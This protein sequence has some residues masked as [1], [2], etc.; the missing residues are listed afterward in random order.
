MAKNPICKHCNIEMVVKN[1]GKNPTTERALI[2][3]QCPKCKAI[4]NVDTKPELDTEEPEID[5]VLIQLIARVFK[6]CNAISPPQAG[7][8][9][10]C[11]FTALIG[12]SNNVIDDNTMLREVGTDDR[13]FQP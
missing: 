10:L 3:F 13:D 5:D 9:T 7:L 12:T 4:Y 11:Y 2:S 1:I 6:R 8:L